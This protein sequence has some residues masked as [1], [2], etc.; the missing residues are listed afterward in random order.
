MH[1][2]RRPPLPARSPGAEQQPWVQSQTT[3]AVLHR[4]EDG[5]FA[6]RTTKQKIWVEGVSY[7]LQVRQG[8]CAQ[9]GP[10]I[11]LGVGLGLDCAVHLKC[12]GATAVVD[13]FLFSTP[14]LRRWW[15]ALQEI[16]G[17]EQ[18]V[19]A[20]RADADDADNEERLCVIC[21]VNERDTTVLPCRHM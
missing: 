16:Y 10:G 4:E 3:F 14:P 7:E 21:L 15:S 12:R 11:G 8:G 13:P 9:Q 20:A 17:L 19:A 18:S 5:S 6:V 2:P 1:H